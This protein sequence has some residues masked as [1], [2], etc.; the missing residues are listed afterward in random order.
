MRRFKDV[1]SIIESFHKVHSQHLVDLSK[2]LLKN[3]ILQTKLNFMEI[4]R[5]SWIKKYLKLSP[6]Y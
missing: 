1:H 5:T 2:R 3:Q 6:C 4:M